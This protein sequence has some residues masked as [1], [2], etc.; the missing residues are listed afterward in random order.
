MISFHQFVEHMRKEQEKKFQGRL[1]IEVQRVKKNNGVL[2]VSLIGKKPEEQEGLMVYLDSYYEVYQE[3]MALEWLADDIYDMFNTFEKP[4]F[5]LEELGDFE[6]VKDKIFYKLINY[7]RNLDMLKDIPHIPYLDLAITFHVMVMRD[8]KGQS[9]CPITHDYRKKW[10]K[11]IGT[12]Y[13]LAAENTPRWFPASIESMNQ[14]M[15]EMMD[16]YQE[17]ND[18]GFGQELFFYDQKDIPL[19]VM[20]NLYGINGAMVI[21][22][23][24]LLNDFSS[25]VESDL[26]LLPSSVH[27]V[28]LLPYYDKLDIKR[29]K[30]MVGHINRTEVSDAD[31]LSDNVYWYDRE[32]DKIS[33]M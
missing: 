8:E 24:E 21:L 27:E 22:Y 10:G 32:N 6:Q 2:A 14:V 3:G 13:A 4:D 28:L 12:L 7:D 18:M 9:T 29:L 15:E 23:P 33:I 25:I 30:E 26:V 5:P 11:D 16:A 31:I 1:A 17:D 20:C 19:Y